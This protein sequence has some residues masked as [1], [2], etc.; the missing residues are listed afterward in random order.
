[1]IT[2]RQ[3]PHRLGHHTIALRPLAIALLAAGLAT[4]ALAVDYVWMGNA[5]GNWADASRWSLL[6]VPG[7]G[8][9]AT[10]N[11]SNH[12]VVLT[13][14]RSVGT[15][16]LTQGYLGG[17]GSLNAGHASF[18]SA[19]LGRADS[20]QG[21]LNVSG[22]TSFAGTNITS[23]RYGQV[24]SLQGDATWSAGNGRIEVGQPYGGS[25]STAPYRSSQLNI[26]AG[27]TFTDAG[28]AAAA[29]TKQI[30]YD[31]GQVN[32]AGTYVRNGLGTTL[33]SY[34]FNNTGTVQV[35]AGTFGL[36]G[37]GSLRGQSSGQINVAAGATLLLGDANV[38]AGSIN[39]SGRVL[40][41]SGLADVAAAA[42][43][44]GD[45]QITGSNAELRLAGNHSITTLAVTSGY[46]GGTAVLNTGSASFVGGVLGRAD[47]TENTLNVSGNTSFAGGNVTTLRYGQVL[48]LNGDATWTAGNGRIEVGQAYGGGLTTAPYRTS[49]L[50]IAA[51]TTFTDAGAAAAAGTKQIG[52]DGGQVNNA[53][54]YVR[55]GLGT[56]LASY[57]FNNTGTVLVEAGR[58]AL[59]DRAR[60]D[61]VISI[62]SGAVLKGVDFS[63]INQGTLRGTGTVET[64]N[65]SSAL[66]NLGHLQP[67]S[68]GGG[69]T[70]ALTGDL[71]LGASGSLD[72]DLVGLGLNDRLAISS[73]L[74]AGG[75]LAVWAAGYTLNLGDSFVIATYDSLVAGTRF[76]QV[77]WNGGLAADVFD[78]QYNA[79]DITLRVTAVPEPQT[80]L[81]LLGGLAG[82]GGLGR[83]R[84][85]QRKA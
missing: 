79:H 28:A 37:N 43:I 4:P 33:G 31:G 64:Y 15:L 72:I 40:L 76:G 42:A 52:Y 69:G 48:N 18:G 70:L 27:T 7:A 17:S 77:S 85:L 20:T 59:D 2:T 57:G 36:T 21:T 44:N 13:D 62:A 11:N 68:N 73:D 82:L 26:A 75:T 38:T 19:V 60:N 14:A 83:R 54:T 50:N 24:L 41:S 81:M 30:G 5:A 16:F 1:M 71:V 80:W 51:G 32:N 55:N 63:F 56:T 45:W 22:S 25:P 58:F 65:L 23:L 6:G 8:D 66:S 10:L 3:H 9:T 29:G 39:N 35:N 49:Q 78:V 46:L 47:S 61:G 53:G 74:T 67:G 12:A 34:G 84:A